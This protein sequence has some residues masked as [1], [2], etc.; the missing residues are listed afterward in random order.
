[1]I[2]QKVFPLSLLFLW[3]F[4]FLFIVVTVNGKQNRERN[5]IWHKRKLLFTLAPFAEAEREEKSKQKQKNK[6]FNVKL[7]K[8]RY[9]CLPMKVFPFYPQHNIHHI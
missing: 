6:S 2:K 9:T 8:A 3:M 4:F 1:V 7:L 5:G